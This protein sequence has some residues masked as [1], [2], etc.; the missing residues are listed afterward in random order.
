M[1]KWSDTGDLKKTG[2]NLAV[3]PVEEKAFFELMTLP[4]EGECLGVKRKDWRFQRFQDPDEFMSEGGT[5]KAAEL[6]DGFEW[7]APGKATVVDVGVNK[8][9]QARSPGLSPTSHC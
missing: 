9:L 8:T 6:H 2:P 1:I 3:K 5:L 7:G 4:E